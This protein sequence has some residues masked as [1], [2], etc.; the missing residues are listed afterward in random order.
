MA[1]NR[2][3]SAG[4]ISASGMTAERLRM[5]VIANNIANANSTKSANGGPFR[6][7]EVIFA[8]VMEEFAGK[9]H[10]TSTGL[11]GV[12][13]V[14]IVE[15]PSELPKLHMPAHPDADKDGYVTMPN[16][17]LPIEMVNLMRKL[18]GA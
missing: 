13:A 16:I 14:Q 1:V 6:R 7:Q 18:P 11:K 5:E 3:F 8:A 12:E 17:H 10:P 4:A 15:D 9:G 2:L